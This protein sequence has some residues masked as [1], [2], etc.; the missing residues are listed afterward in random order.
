[1]QAFFFV[2]PGLR[3][4]LC[5]RTDHLQAKLQVICILQYWSVL[6]RQDLCLNLWASI[7]LA[8]FKMIL[9]KN[10]FTV[11]SL[12]RS[13]PTLFLR[14]TRIRIPSVKMS[15]ANFWNLPIYSFKKTDRRITHMTGRIGASGS[16]ILTNE[17]HINWNTMF[18]FCKPKMIVVN[19]LSIYKYHYR[20]KLWGFVFCGPSKSN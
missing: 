1:M 2:T 15:S 8:R 6:C 7:N 16:Q 14:Y 4:L 3:Q 12:Y 20:C 18:V 19:S 9:L 17:G 13:A 11:D 5:S 10:I